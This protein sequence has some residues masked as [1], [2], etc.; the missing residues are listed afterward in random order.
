M[1]VVK[2]PTT[3]PKDI[4]QQLRIAHQRQLAER[5]S[6]WLVDAELRLGLDETRDI[7]LSS[8]VDVEAKRR[9]VK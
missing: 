5:M 9:A 7:L 3:A 1:T 6:A 2:I 4:A 8:I